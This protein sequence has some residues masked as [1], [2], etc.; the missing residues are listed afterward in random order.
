LFKHL[1]ESVPPKGV[2][3]GSIVVDPEDHITEWMSHAFAGT[4]GGMEEVVAV[5]KP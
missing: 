2:D 5:V 4:S 3:L 1:D